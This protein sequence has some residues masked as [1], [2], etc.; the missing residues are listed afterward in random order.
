[1]KRRHE[2]DERRIQQILWIK[3]GVF[4][5]SAVVFV[6]YALYLILV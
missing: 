4:V 1:M 2:V 3:V 5:F 6:A